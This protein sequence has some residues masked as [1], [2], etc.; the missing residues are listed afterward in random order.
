MT[1]LLIFPILPI[2]TSH[3]EQKNAHLGPCNGIIANIVL[4][5]LVIPAALTV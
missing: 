1:N 3:T 5:F 2:V 4:Q